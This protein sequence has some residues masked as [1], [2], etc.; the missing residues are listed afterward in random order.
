MNKDIIQ[1][2][3]SR[4]KAEF[5]TEQ[6]GSILKLGGILYETDDVITLVVKTSERLKGKLILLKEEEKL[7]KARI[8]KEEDYL[9]KISKLKN[10]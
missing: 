8:K 3:F 9:K 1:L 2:R 7:T 10:A 5:E 4:K 6:P